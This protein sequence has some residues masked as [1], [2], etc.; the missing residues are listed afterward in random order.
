MTIA[1]ALS[2]PHFWFGVATAM[3]ETRIYE[4]IQELRAQHGI[5]IDTAVAFVAEQEQLDEDALMVEHFSWCIDCYNQ[6]GA[7]DR[8]GAQSVENH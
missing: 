8:K 6:H 7:D 5:R 1:V 2:R 4:R 3:F